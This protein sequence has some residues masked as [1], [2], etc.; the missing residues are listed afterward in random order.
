[1]DF[2]TRFAH[3]AKDTSENDSID[4]FQTK[5]G[6]KNPETY[7]NPE[8]ADLGEDE[9]AGDIG[10]PEVRCRGV[11]WEL[12]KE[13]S[14]RK[15]NWPRRRKP[16]DHFFQNKVV[17]KSEESDGRLER[18]LEKVTQEYHRAR[19]KGRDIEVF[20]KWIDAEDDGGA[21]DGVD[22][23]TANLGQAAT[24]G[25]NDEVFVGTIK[26]ESKMPGWRKLRNGITMDSGSAV[27][28]TPDDE[29][30]EFETV[31][32]TGSRIGR[33]LGAAN[34]TPI[35]VS[36]EKW[37]TFGT[38]EG[39]ELCWPFIAGKVKKTLKSVGTS[40]DAGNYV[41]FY[42]DRGYIVHK[43]TRDYIQ[44]DRVGNVYVI[45]VWVKIG[46]RADKAASGF[47][48]QVATP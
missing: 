1:M 41:I 48:R 11:N 9:V 12:S 10:D 14:D 45:D 21:L 16:K 38:N 46:S 30:P 31:P 17:E 6:I 3:I 5:Y 32:L 2:Q 40:C 36:G 8:M 33:R 35:Q 24:P 7:W 27:D 25:E 47:T 15:A 29:N 20:V 13:V 4:T 39:W 44:F 37:I 43:A 42:D 28:I 23:I 26:D 22:A 19:A 18:I 34:G